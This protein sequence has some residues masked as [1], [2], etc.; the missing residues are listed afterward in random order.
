MNRDNQDNRHQS[1]RHDPIRF[2]GLSVALAAA[3]ASSCMS[4]QRGADD[5]NAASAVK[6][7][8][9]QS[10]G[11][12]ARGR[13]RFL[14]FHAPAGDQPTTL[15]TTIDGRSGAIL[16]NGRFVTP[17]GLEFNVGA[18]KPFG[19][20]VSPDE[21][22]LATINSGA[23]RFSVTLI[24]NP[25]GA[26]PTVTPVDARTRPSWASCSRPTAR[27]STPRAARTA[28]SGSATSRPGTVIGSVNLNGPG[29]PARPHPMSPTADP[30]GTSRA[31]SPA[32]WR[33]RATAATCTSSI[34]ELPGLTS[35]TPPAIA[36]GRRRRRQRRR[37]RQLRRGRRPHEG[38]ALSRSASA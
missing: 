20:A 14:D 10:S 22:T 3:G 24:R 15:A 34:R 23:S 31:R 16:A 13:S 2:V 35:S 29:P 8:A 4:D 9:L 19:L 5:P 6:Q 33:C 27:A 21:Q 32:T 11:S 18:P 28:T 26:S 12:G 25:R 36:T 37:A 7:G 1:H 17:A 30:A 38:R